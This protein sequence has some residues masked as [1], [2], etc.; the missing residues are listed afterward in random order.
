MPDSGDWS[1][2]TAERVGEVIVQERASCGLMRLACGRAADVS[3]CD[4][5]G[6]YVEVVGMA[7]E[8]AGD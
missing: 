8:F 2:P 3:F 7:S 1:G 6:L 4:L 5:L